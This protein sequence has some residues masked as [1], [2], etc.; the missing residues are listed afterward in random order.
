MGLTIS[1]VQ[2]PVTPSK[3]SVVAR[4]TFDNSYPTGG[5]PLA[6]SALGLKAF[7]WVEARQEGVGS[8]LV[9]FNYSTSSLMLFTALGTEAGNG[10]DQ[11]TIVVRVL[12]YGPDV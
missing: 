1:N 5:L 6:P 7:K 3:E 8:R 2:R 12:A 9:E 11:S 4:V 10:T